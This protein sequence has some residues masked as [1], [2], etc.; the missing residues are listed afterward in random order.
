MDRLTVNSCPPRHGTER[1]EGT[2]LK[3]R[4]GLCAIA[5]AIVVAAGSAY[6]QNRDIL[7]LQR[8]MIEVQTRVKQLQTTMD[9]V[10]ALMKSLLEKTADQVNTLTGGMQKISQT[11]DGMKGQ[12]DTSAR[13]LRTLVSTLTAMVKEMEENLSAARA[14]IG[15]VSREITTLKTT[16]EP[17][18]NPDDLW[19]SA[20]LDYSLGSYDL[21]ATGFEEFISKFPSDPRIP[22]AHLRLGDALVAQKKYEQAFAEYDFV[23]QKVPDSDKSRTALFKKGLALAE[24]NPKQAISTL[25]EVVQKFPGTS[26]ANAAQAKLKEL[27]QP[28]QRGRTPAR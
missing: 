16:T 24:T 1:S 21:A 10:N 7:Q 26:E 2:T 19:R 11:V 8:D 28:A 12:N 5:L 20:G 14:Q 22:D 18:A 25:N 15:S 23:L 3:T 17:L 4:T 13:E 6:P 27:Q 9:Q